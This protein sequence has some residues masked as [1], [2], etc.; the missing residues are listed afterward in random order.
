MSKEKK[1][2]KVTDAEIV[3]VEKSVIEPGKEPAVKE[4]G[5]I[6]IPKRVP[7]SMAVEGQLRCDKCFLSEACAFFKAA[8]ECSLGITAEINGSKDVLDFSKKMLSIAAERVMR[9]YHFEKVN[10]GVISPEVD[11]AMK[12]FMDLTQ[13]VKDIGDNRDEITIKA[14]GGG[15]ISQLFGNMGQGKK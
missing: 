6:E 2:D 4:E 8:A 9:A 11:Q 10:G 15:I 5:A 3:P 12:Q 14:R 1:D 13:W 7:F